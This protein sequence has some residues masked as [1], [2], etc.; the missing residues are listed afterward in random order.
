VVASGDA[1]KQSPGPSETPHLTDICNGGVV[2]SATDAETNGKCWLAYDL[3]QTEQIEAC[4]LRIFAHRYEQP[5]RHPRGTHYLVVVRGVA[6]VWIDGVMIEMNVGDF[7]EIPPNS[8]H[9]VGA[10]AD[11]DTWVAVVTHPRVVPRRTEVDSSQGST[12]DIAYHTVW[13]G[14]REDRMRLLN[15]KDPS[16]EVRLARFT[17]IQNGSVTPGAVDPKT[18]GQIWEICYVV[19]HESV[20]I[21]YGHVLAGKMTGAHSHPDG[22]H[23]LVIVGGSAL[24]WMDG[25]LTR[26]DEGDFIE[27]PRDSLHNFAAGLS[28]DMWNLSLTHPRVDHKKDQYNESRE[29]DSIAVLQRAWVEETARRSLSCD[30]TE[31]SE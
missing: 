12:V 13:H 19:E 27:I 1:G 16:R 10:S 18:N 2:P 9:A 7:V 3:V 15:R 31:K 30:G 4:Y 26:F 25:K 24:L 6:L 11:Q 8:L 21:H 29:E 22:S 14:K 28:T 20:E 5:H 23:Y 17:E